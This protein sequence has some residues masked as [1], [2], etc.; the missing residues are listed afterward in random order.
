MSDPT[1]AVFKVTSGRANGHEY[2]VQFNPETVS[3]S[4]SADWAEKKGDH[5]LDIP[6]VEWKG[7]KA[8]K[9][10][11]TLFFDTY[12]DDK[13]VRDKTQPI[14]ELSMVQDETHGPPILEFLSGGKAWYHRN[15]KGLTWNLTSFSTT[16]KMFNAQGVPV[17]AEMKVGLTEYATEEQQKARIRLQS[18]DH[19]KMHRV[20]PGDTLHSIAMEAYND[21]SK[22]RPIAEANSIEDP[23][24]LQPGAVLRVPRTR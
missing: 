19:E 16:Y 21:P 3:L 22:W 4:K 6:L 23:L 15:D 13:D 7:G 2:T 12:E 9:L 17:R 10:E 18:P 8:L 14:E 24:D 1:K 20:R 5:T 11:M